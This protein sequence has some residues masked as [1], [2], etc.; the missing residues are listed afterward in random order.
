MS[1]MEG[2]Q[3]LKPRHHHHHNPHHPH[4]PGGS[5]DTAS[6]SQSHPSPACSR[7]FDFHIS[8]INKSIDE[9]PM[10]HSVILSS[11]N[12]EGESPIQSLSQLV[13]NLVAPI[14]PMFQFNQ[15]NH[16]RISALMDD[17]NLCDK[18]PVSELNPSQDSEQSD[19]T[20]VTIVP[21]P[22]PDGSTVLNDRESSEVGCPR[23]ESPV[24]APAKIEI[25]PTTQDIDVDNADHQGEGKNIG[26]VL[27][28]LKDKVR[29]EDDEFAPV[30]E[31]DETDTDYDNKPTSPKQM[32]NPKLS[33]KR[34]C[35]DDSCD[36]DESSLSGPGK[37]VSGLQRHYKGR[38]MKIV[39]QVF[40][41]S[42]KL[43]GK[44]AKLL[45]DKV[46]EILQV[47][48]GD[49]R[50]W[51]RTERDEWC[52]DDFDKFRTDPELNEAIAEWKTFPSSSTSSRSSKKP[53][54]SR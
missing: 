6:S 26:H 49:W 12:T 50:E 46:E 51:W 19:P 36:D 45:G 43:S 38:V 37:R 35:S 2:Q 40:G 52:Q 17:V 3:H 15:T 23:C 8:S 34:K 10:S 11:P 27:A 41:L 25:V 53:R 47:P 31:D 30:S 22:E 33:R 21:E 7:F 4:V 1:T 39:K 29:T 9:L 14:L 32:S 5:P 18:R 16:Q 13:E 44:S 54:R 28:L 48:G 20:K 24:A 42:G